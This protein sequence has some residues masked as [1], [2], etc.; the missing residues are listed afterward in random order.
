MGGMYVNP[1]PIPTKPPKNIVKLQNDVINELAKTP[2]RKKAR[3][4]IIDNLGE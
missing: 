3:P 4:M 2:D 1:N